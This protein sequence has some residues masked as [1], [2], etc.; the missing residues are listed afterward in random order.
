MKFIKGLKLSEDFYNEVVKNII[1]K[2]FPDLKYSA[3]LMDYGSEILGFDTAMSRDHWWGPRVI[4]FLEQ[5]DSLKYKDKID[6]ALSEKLPL[7]FK[8]YST[9]F[10]GKVGDQTRILEPVKSGRVAHLIRIVTAEDFF[11]E[12]LGFN[13]NKRIEIEDWL[14]FSQQKLRLLH[15]GKLFHDN[16]NVKDAI[17]KLE[18]YPKDIWLYLMASEWQRISEEKAFVGRSGETGNEIGS[19]IIATRIIESIMRLCF[20]MEKQYMPYS[21]WF[22]LAFNQ[23]KC[24]SDFLPVFKKVLNA[25]KWQKREKFLAKAYKIIAQKHNFLQ[26]TKKLPVEVS[27]YYNRKYLVLHADRFAEELRKSIKNKKLK[28]TK[29]IGSIDQVV[30][31]SVIPDGNKTENVFKQ[32][33]N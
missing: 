4:I 25:K 20:L 6:R 14:V 15:D 22:G 10:S 24:S 31:F 16:L 3:G 17:N 23:L 12:H 9:N 18:Y 29:L 32:L 21:K 26:V 11:Q 33:Y 8:G 7:E 13:F 1:E 5:D 27:K 2:E 19:R 28:E 30:N